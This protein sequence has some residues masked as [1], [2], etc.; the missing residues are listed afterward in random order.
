MMDQ[1]IKFTT[2][3]DQKWLKAEEERLDKLEKLTGLK[4]K[5]NGQQ[6]TFGTSPA[7]LNAEKNL[8]GV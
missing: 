8:T 2:G 3:S 5:S 1:I 4:K 6:T 7:F